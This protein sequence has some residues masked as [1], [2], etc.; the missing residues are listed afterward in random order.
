VEACRTG[1]VGPEPDAVGVKPALEHSVSARQKF[2][3]TTQLL[4]N[5]RPVEPVLTNR[6]PELANVYSFASQYILT[7][8][9]QLF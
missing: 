7:N 4:F 3:I 2:K 6:F 8:Y 1:V 9:T 5:F